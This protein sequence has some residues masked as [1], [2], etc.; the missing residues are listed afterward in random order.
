MKQLN[1]MY[2]A[3]IS[4]FEDDGAFSPN[5]QSNIL[6][7]VAQQGLDGL[8]ISGSSGESALMSCEELMEQQSLIA[9]ER[10][11]EFGN[12]IAHVGMPS[13]RESVILA[14]QAKR[15]GFEAL[16]ALPP[17]AYPF[18][19]EEI[20]EYYREI[21][22]ATDLPFIVYE[23]PL[24]THRPLPIELIH[25]LADLQNVHGIKFTSQDLYKL[26]TIR[27]SRPDLLCY[28]GF[29]EMFLGAAALGCDGGIGTTYNVLGKLYVAL[30][31][32][33]ANHDLATARTLQKLSQEYVDILMTTG[34]LPGVKL[35]LELIGYEVG[36]SRAPFSLK[37]QT[38]KA[39]LQAFLERTDT[40]QWIA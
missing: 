3:L 18:S 29:D 38:A 31:S 22:S 28:F 15:L 4:G 2:A 37:S 27:R 11:P 32:A 23:I 34:V 26:A 13:T 10:A 14:K 5:R 36:P 1:G 9:S 12:I 8:Y 21:T 25:Q 30:Q 7:Y 40:K 20:L 24:R 17:H 16:S 19:D 6:R 33:V 35:T 39:D